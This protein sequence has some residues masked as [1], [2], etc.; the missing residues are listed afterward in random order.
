MLLEDTYV[1]A[2]VEDA[3]SQL[4][5]AASSKE[6][7]ERYAAEGKWYDAFLWAEQYWQ[8]QVKTADVGIRAKELLSIE[9]AKEQK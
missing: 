7:Y 3:F 9:L 1:N 5:Q 2:L 8:Y 6:K 4:G